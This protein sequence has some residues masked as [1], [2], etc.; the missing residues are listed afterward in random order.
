MIK[1]DKTYYITS[2]SQ[3]IDIQSVVKCC[4]NFKNILDDFEKAGKYVIDAGNICDKKALSIDE[5]TL[6]Y[7]ITQRGTEIKKVKKLYTEQIDK[8][9]NAARKLYYEQSNALAEYE[10]KV[11]LENAKNS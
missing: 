7:D 5:Q 1:V 6:K 9:I 11:A 4:D 3:I 10:R 8:L 2:R